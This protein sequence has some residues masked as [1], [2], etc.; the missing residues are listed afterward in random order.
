MATI[1]VEF[2]GAEYPIVVGENTQAALL[3]ATTA[4]T[5]ADRAEA[6]ADE[7]R[8]VN[9]SASI[10]TPISGAS[11]VV[12]AYANY[13][14][15]ALISSVNHRYQDFTV[16]AGQKVYASALIRGTLMA[17]AVFYDA[18]DVYLGF[19][20]RA[21]L[22]GLGLVYE[23][24][25]LVVP[26]N[27]VKLRM[28]QS[29]T[30][31]V[32][33]PMTLET[34]EV[35]PDLAGAAGMVDELATSLIELYPE[36]P[37]ESGTGSYVNKVNGQLVTFAGYKYA[38]FPVTP[39]ETI[40]CSATISG[41][42]TALIVFTNSS[43]AFISRHFEALAGPTTYTE[44]AQVVPAGAAFASMTC[45]ITAGALVLAKEI[46][47]PNIGRRVAALEA[48]AGDP[49]VGYWADKSVV[50]IGNSIPN[51]ETTGNYP[52]ILASELGF[53]LTRETTSGMA[54]RAGVRSRVTGGDPYG[55]SGS[56]WQALLW[57]L[58]MTLTE[59]QYLIDNWS[60]IRTGLT[61]GPP[62]TLS[63]SQQELAIS[64]CYENRLVARNLGSNR[65]DWYI[66]DNPFNDRSM[67]DDIATAGLGSED[68][69]T[70]LGVMNAMIRL[71][72]EDHPAAKIAIV[73]HYENQEFPSLVNSQRLVADAWGI[74]LLST[75]DKLGWSQRVITVDGSWSMAGVLGTWVSGSGVQTLT[76]LDRN[77]PDGI[78]PA[79][80]TSGEALLRQAAAI[81]VDFGRL[82]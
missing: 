65:K 58:G 33:N 18:S 38:R 45:P 3:A 42:A 20:V 50:W 14:T 76:V 10:F 44:Q 66:F 16:T 2:G 9:E 36:T 70:Y 25:P 82:R 56:P 1:N 79:R 80:D 52:S 13:S 51:G 75:H 41:V 7:I 64:T 60:T 37:S 46:T 4:T 23:R 24:E 32:T 43:G 68:R 49:D 40:F 54:H 62:T 11:V 19:A 6:A 67:D 34:A 53:T 48:G 81:K 22:D 39:G 63:T 35:F 29:N 15:G 55:W 61:A 30:A 73:G 71:I 59:K 12:G 72:Y 69:L 31:S 28:S 21:P 77:V 78:H 26:P 74:P 5:E 27:A 57:S 8:A 17:L 47:S